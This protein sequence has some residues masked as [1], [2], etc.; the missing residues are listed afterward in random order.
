[1]IVPGTRERVWLVKGRVLRLGGKGLARGL[2]RT[3]PR[4]LAAVREAEEMGETYDEADD[5]YR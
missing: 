4:I 2:S 1:M 5:R 3:T